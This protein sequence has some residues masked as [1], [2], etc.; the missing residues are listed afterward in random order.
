MRIPA[1]VELIFSW[2]LILVIAAVL[3]ASLAT[4]YIML[5]KVAAVAE[6]VEAR[7]GGFTNVVVLMVAPFGFA[8][9]VTVVLLHRYTVALAGFMILLVATGRAQDV[10]GVTGYVAA[11]GFQQVIS[12]T[13]AMILFLG[14]VVLADKGG[15]RYRSVLSDRVFQI[16]LLFAV[17]TTIS[18]FLNHPPVR[19]LWL[20]L[21]GAWQYV[22][23]YVVASA[24]IDSDE[25]AHVLV[26]SLVLT[27][28][29]GVGLRILISGQAFL[30]I[31]EEGVFW[32]AR[33]YAFGPAASYGGILAVSAIL[34]LYLSRAALDFRGV[35]LWTLVVVV[36]A[37]ELISTGTRGAALSLIAV[38]FLFFWKGERL[39]AVGVGSVVVMASF[40]LGPN[41][42]GIFQ[43]R[44]IYL[45]SRILDL[46]NVVGRWELIQLHLPHFFDGWGFGYGI[47]RQLSLFVTSVDQVLPAHNIFLLVSQN[48]GGLAALAFMAVVLL[49]AWRLWKSAIIVQNLRAKQMLVYIFVAL[50]AWLIFAN[51]TGISITYYY[52]YEV[53]ILFLVVVFVAALSGRLIPEGSV[54]GRQRTTS[55]A[56]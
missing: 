36:I 39:Y 38:G 56:R 27:V 22:A 3:A 1:K 35:V 41:L 52:P 34:A 46:P 31:T 16:L 53:N 54:R 28:L 37:L 49:S 17:F 50:S 15:G 23:L 7:A 13:T 5:P 11:D 42:L 55:P 8:A 14:V 26:R 24:A 43:Q 10:V 21:G 2:R 4:P 25:D 29:I 48:A 20:S 45:D 6:Q 30:P 44:P 9:W 18:Q 33:G 51:T 40:A 12:V 32:R 47:G 19:A